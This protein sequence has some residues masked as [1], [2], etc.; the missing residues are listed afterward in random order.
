M[1]EKA[2]KIKVLFLCTGNACR[3][4]M[5]E[6]LARALRSDCIDA[7]SAGLDP[8][9]LDPMAIE[10]MA[11]AGL[12]ISSQR[13]KHVDQMKDIQFDYVIT[14]CDGAHESCPVFP[15]KAKHMHAGFPDPPS[16]ASHAPDKQQALGYYRMVRDQI[17]RFIEGMPGNLT[18]R[19][20]KNE[21]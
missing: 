17:K 21:R 13:S 1:S 15:G 20:H 11:E 18:D 4:Q 5:A 3:S 10:V 7:Y 2:Q 12:D 14:L 16:L 8:R 19:E 9:G 6:G